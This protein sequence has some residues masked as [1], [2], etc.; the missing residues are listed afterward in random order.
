MTKE[1]LKKD[2]VENYQA[3]IKRKLKVI[4]HGES[5]ERYVEVEFLYFII[6]EFN[7]LITKL[8]RLIAMNRDWRK[9]ETK[10]LEHVNKEK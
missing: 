7:D 5:K 9:S 2:L 6:A 3:T 8:E 10:V 4:E 1:E